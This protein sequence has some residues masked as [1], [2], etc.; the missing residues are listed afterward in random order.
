MFLVGTLA[1]QSTTEQATQQGLNMFKHMGNKAPVLAS[2]SQDKIKRPN[3]GRAHAHEEKEEKMVE[4]EKRIVPLFRN[5]R[6][7]M[8]EFSSRSGLVP[9]PVSQ[10]KLNETINATKKDNLSTMNIPLEP[11]YNST[12]ENAWLCMHRGTHTLVDPCVGY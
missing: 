6:A 9:P 7:M 12:F 4:E 1:A 8:D 5:V 2:A 11:P 3:A 10:D